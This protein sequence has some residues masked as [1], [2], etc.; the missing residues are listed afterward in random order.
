MEAM[1]DSDCHACGDR[2]LAG[3]AI[4]NDDDRWVHEDCGGDDA[5]DPPESPAMEQRRI[6]AAALRVL[7]STGDVPDDVEYDA[8]AT[9]MSEPRATGVIAALGFAGLVQGNPYADIYAPCEPQ[10][11]LDP[12][13]DFDRYKRYRLQH[14]NRDAVLVATRCTTLKGAASDTYNLD[15]WRSANVA[16]G[17]A[18]RPDLLALAGSMGPDDKRIH[19]V[20][21]DAEDAGGGS[22][23][24]NMGTAIHAYTEAVDHGA[25][26]SSIPP[27]QRA[28]IRAYRDALTH[29]KLT[30]IPMAIER[31]TMTSRWDG[32]AG[33]FDRIYRTHDGRFVIGDVKSGKVGYDNKEMFAQFAMYAQGANEVGVYDVAA[34]AW[35][36]LP[37]TVDTD[38]A[39]IM[40]VPAG[41]GTCTVYEADLAVGREHLD[42]CAAV[43]RHRKLKHPLPRY[44]AGPMDESDWLEPIRRATTRDQ[45]SEIGRMIKAA[46]SMTDDLRAAA[47][48]RMEDFP[49]EG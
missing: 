37:F 22:D 49:N 25:P 33:T 24:A 35:V 7:G 46:K 48:S 12:R 40:H 43:R 8:S 23:K 13:R 47:R 32:V 18:R 39:L 41:A 36:R 17:F 44:E 5:V 34:R 31:I 6:E 42:M 2:I 38:T 45:L 28:D 27:A 21:K 16:R 11:K 4:V 29:E 14:P 30:V 26:L 9:L 3:T 19:D 15:R 10:P 20:I 1:Y